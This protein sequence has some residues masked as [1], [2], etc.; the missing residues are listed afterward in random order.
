MRL[1][2]K[3]LCGALSLL[4][5]C[6]MGAL[7]PAAASAQASQTD[8][9]L[10]TI[11]KRDKLIVATFS[12]APPFGFTDE[13]GKLVGFDIDI[14]RLIAKSL[15]GDENKVEFVSVTSEGRWPAV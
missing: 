7:I 10:Q 9:R 15:L 8:S 6:S 14:S 1:S 2:L 11:L 4:I 5:G 13:K 12:T 3:K